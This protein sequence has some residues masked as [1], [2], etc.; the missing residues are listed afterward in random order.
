M[1][2]FRGLRLVAR[3]VSC[4]P[5]DAGEQLFLARVPA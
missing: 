4:R 5:L 2:Q 3:Q 1:I